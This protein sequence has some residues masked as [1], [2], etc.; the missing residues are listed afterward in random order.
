M[1]L[2]SEDVIRALDGLRDK[3]L[4]WEA[5]SASTRV[6]KY[7]H[8]IDETL[9]LSGV[10]SAI[11]CELLVRGPQTAGE[12]RTRASRLLDVGSRDDVSALLSSLSEREDG[13]L[14]VL[15][16]REPG[17]RESRYAHLLC[18][19]PDMEA[20]APP[21]E[22]ARVAVHETDTRVQRIEGRVEKL[23]TAFEDL[24]QRLDSFMHQ[25]E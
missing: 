11:L 14:V 24:R 6:P 3:K 13:P 5:T 17:K 2:D 4:A 10:Q 8:R 7:K 21:P 1:A 23:E 16:P 20:P 25:F 19:T 15:L 22:P 18:G 9:G 12:L